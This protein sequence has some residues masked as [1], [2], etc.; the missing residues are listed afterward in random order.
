MAASDRSTAEPEPDS[1]AVRTA[2]WRA[3]HVQVDAP[4]HVFE[5]EVGLALAAPPDGWRDRQDMHPQ[6]TRGFRAA[7]VSRA[8]FVED[9][10]VEQ[11]GRGVDQYAILGA[12]LD[13]FVQ[14]RPELAARVT[15]FEVDRPG[16]Q[17]WKRQ[18]L[19][20]AGFGI[21]AS[22][23]LVPVDFEGGASWWQRLVD[24]GFDRARPA[25]VGSTGVTMYLTRDAI[26]ATLRQLAAL[27]PGS[28]VAMTFMLPLELLEPEDR[29]WFEWAK[30]SAEASGTPF[31]TA[32]APDEMVALARE[33]GF[34]GARHVSGLE[35]GQRYFGGRP[36]GLRPSSG[37]DFLVA[38]T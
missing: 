15:V 18:R 34:A 21:P 29:R 32:F 28:T 33:A 8:R 1:T 10:V 4:P 5:D 14:R 7:M 26:A 35:L 37:E 16:P 25:V 31:A 27:A 11:I 36:D 9:L 12:G 20:D 19:I 17:A 30:K 3:M 38:T 13:T 6:W 23:R 2:L 24:E 22:L